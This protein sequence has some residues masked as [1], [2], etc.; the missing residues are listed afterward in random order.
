MA[1]LICAELTSRFSL[2]IFGQV[3][4]PLCLYYFSRAKRIGCSC[5]LRGERVEKRD[6]SICRFLFHFL[7]PVFFLISN[8][9]RT[10]VNRIPPT[11]LAPFLLW[12]SW[13]TYSSFANLTIYILRAS[14]S[15][16]SPFCPLSG[17]STLAH[18]PHQLLFEPVI[19]LLP[20][21][22]SVLLL[23]LPLLKPSSVV[24]EQL[25]GRIFL[26]NLVK[27]AMRL[28]TTTKEAKKQLIL[29]TLHTRTHLF[30]SN[31]FRNRMLS[32]TRKLCQKVA[33]SNLIISLVT[34]ELTLSR[35][36][37]GIA[38]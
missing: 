33:Q 36:S 9:P 24:S 26:L 5:K 1:N 17:L 3:Y 28:N 6:S 4:L 12:L 34:C 19:C 25:K 7:L 16:S 27:A 21:W 35:S 31:K 13:P 8:F 29:A 10:R 20:V 11:L 38:S 18:S 15:I 32:A 14:I 30:I 23:L 37:L 22:N 2:S